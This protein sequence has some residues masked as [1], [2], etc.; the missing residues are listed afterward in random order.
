MNSIDFI[1][2]SIQFTFSPS[3]LEIQCHSSCREFRF[4]S[5]PKSGFLT[6]KKQKSSEKQWLASEVILGSSGESDLASVVIK[7]CVNKLLES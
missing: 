4:R 5:G 7:A 3:R 6:V 2:C 1:S